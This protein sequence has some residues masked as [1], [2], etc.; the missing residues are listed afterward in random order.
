M[1]LLQDKLEDHLRVYQ[2]DKVR[3]EKW[4]EEFKAIA[5]SNAKSI[6]ELTESTKGL[7]DA[8]KATTGAVTVASAVGRVMKWLAGFAVVGVILKW[9]NGA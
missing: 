7:V 2:E 8:W 1:I 5:L 6:H 4:R 9:F 3:D